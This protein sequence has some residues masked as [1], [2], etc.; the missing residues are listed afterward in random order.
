M[1]K[2][3][4]AFFLLEKPLFIMTSSQT[5]KNRYSFC[6]LAMRGEYILRQ[7]RI[8]AAKEVPLSA[9]ICAEKLTYNHR[10]REIDFFQYP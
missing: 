4:I 9:A 10:Q 2:S 8:E 7:R 6:Y 1:A 5:L 3:H